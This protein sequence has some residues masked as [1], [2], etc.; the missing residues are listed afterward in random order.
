MDTV[1]KEQRSLNMSHIRAKNTSIEVKVRKYL[2]SY[3]LGHEFLPRAIVYQVDK[4]I[5]ISFCQILHSCN[6]K[7]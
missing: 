2:F 4:A 7:N 3:P 6:S 5:D 1:S